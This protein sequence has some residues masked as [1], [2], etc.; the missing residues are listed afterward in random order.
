MVLDRGITGGGRAVKASPGSCE[1]QPD[2]ESPGLSDFQGISRHIPHGGELR[3][4]TRL[5]FGDAQGGGEVGTDLGGETRFRARQFPALDMNRR[6]SELVEAHSPC[7]ERFCAV[8]HALRNKESCTIACTIE[9]PE[10]CKQPHQ[11]GVLGRRELAY[12]RLVSH[13]IFGTLASWNLDFGLQMIC[14]IGGSA[15]QTDLTSSSQTSTRFPALLDSVDF[16]TN[17]ESGVPHA[18]SRRS[19]EE[20]SFADGTPS[21][22]MALRPPRWRSCAEPSHRFTRSYIDTQCPG[23]HG[24]ATSST[25][26]RS[27]R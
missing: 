2:L 20:H 15:C 22:G 1:G 11:Y 9:R 4:C 16:E 21:P 26:L 13:A 5:S 12:A 14:P 10:S 6:R 7:N 19:K 24:V 25:L 18:C 3:A 23:P 17:P 8:F 27:P